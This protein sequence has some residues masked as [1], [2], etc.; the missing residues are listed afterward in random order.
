MNEY[1]IINIQEI[2]SIKEGDSYNGE[3]AVF[4]SNSTEDFSLS[5]KTP[6]YVNAFSYVI[7]ISGKAVLN[8]DENKHALEENSI[9][10][11]S[12]LHLTFFSDISDD[13][14]CTFLCIHK[15]FIDKIGVF[16]LKQR[17]AKG[18]NMHSM[19]IAK[20]NHMECCLLDECIKQ[21][22][23]QILR[24]AHI[25][26]LELIQNALI[27]FYLEL[28][29]IL[30]NLTIN[31]IPSNTARYR[32]MLQ[33][34]ISLLMLN[35]KTEHNVPFYAE[36]M[37]ITPQYL[38]SIIKRQTGRTVNSFINE[39]IYSE[40]RNMLVSTKMSIQQIAVSLNFA[41]Q[42][43]FSKFFKRNSGISPQIFRER[44]RK[45]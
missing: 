39:L 43:S 20:I 10:I 2:I 44:I 12:P 45:K 34:F 9:C 41:D 37:N 17:I 24:E 7:V 42:A 36:K 22:K 38:T 33:D 27:K 15:D 11:L 32:M 1:N 19:P 3:I 26:H 23:K 30:D 6:V 31:Y 18:I 28:D 5:G 29:N 16:N 40:A 13:F 4:E 8:I 35:F 25:Y 14:K 21:I